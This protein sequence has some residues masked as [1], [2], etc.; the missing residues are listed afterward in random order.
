MNSVMPPLDC[1]PLKDRH[2]LSSGKAP[3]SQTFKCLLN[4]CSSQKY[5]TARSLDG[6]SL[7]LIIFIGSFCFTWQILKIRSVF[8]LTIALLGLIIVFPESHPP[9]SVHSSVSV[10]FIWIAFCFSKT[11]TLEGLCLG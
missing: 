5:S 9:L 2:S 10:W 1:E 8:I 7:I 3:G 6:I 4:E 11:L